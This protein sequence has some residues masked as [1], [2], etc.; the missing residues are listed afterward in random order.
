MSNERK[1]SCL[2][3]ANH[4]NIIE[5]K[6]FLFRVDGYVLLGYL[7]VAIKF[8]IIS[9]DWSCHF[10]EISELGSLKMG[11]LGDWHVHGCG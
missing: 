8:L 3:Y 7:R 10:V 1:F 4:E 2:S 6:R 5:S 9:C 11:D